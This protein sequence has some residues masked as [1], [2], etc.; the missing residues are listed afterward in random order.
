M[1]TSSGLQWSSR[2]TFLMAAVG[3]AVGLGN[4]WR[5]P[6][7]AGVN[8]GGAFVLVYLGAVAL[9]ALPLLMAE[10]M[11]GRRG[12]H[13]PPAAIAAVARESARS[14]NWRWM[15]LLLGALGALL[16]LS[17][18]AVVGAWT[19]A[20]AF[21]MGAGQLQQV[22]AEDATLVFN[23]LNASPAELLAWFTAFIGATV[24]ISARGLHAGVET[25]VK[26]MMP[27]LF[28]MLVA[29]VIYAGVVGDFSGAVDFMFS[30]DFSKL[31]S[32]V[33]L[34]AFGQAFFTVSVGL[35]NMM[36]Y[37]AYIERTTSLPQASV[38]IVA[39]D[40]CV[41][42][43]AGFAIFPII[44]MHGLEPGAG[45]GLVFMTLPF[46]FGQMPGGLIFGTVFFVLLF[47][48]ALTS[49]IA[50]LEPPVSW[51]RDATSLSRRSAA[52]VAGCFSFVLGILAALSFNLLSD[53][54][55][56]GSI[57]MFEGKTF[58]DLFDYLVTNIMMPLGGILIAVFA[59]WIV[60]TEFS[61]DEL[62]DGKNVFGH[63]AWLFL[64]R[65]VAPAVLAFVLVDM[66][67]S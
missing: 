4:I 50:M 67:S 41:A 52:I 3:C 26:F 39:A 20:Y 32:R 25:A 5:F 10:F 19:I 14:E 9:L 45:P 63:N 51:L 40:T 16:A 43:L 61:R 42:L 17:F 8:G 38:I 34:G 65:F 57:G 48:A 33:V 7:T 6:Y 44:F 29:M 21:K 27:A 55:P 13:G 28:V 46:A 30:A 64:V 31:N 62:F 23:I 24:F 66:A 1:T 56:L 37:G 35:T 49:S 18:Y 22:S 12:Q 47:F 60:K 58:F 11:V 15:G 36:A 54:H 59:G 2:I 53:V